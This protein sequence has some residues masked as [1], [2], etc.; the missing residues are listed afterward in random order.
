[1][2]QAVIETAGWLLFSAVVLALIAG[3]TAWLPGYLVGIPIWLA[4][5]LLIPLVRRSQLRQ[6]G[7]L[8]GIGL[9][10]LLFGIL[11]GADLRYLLQALGA[12]HSVVGMLIGVSFLRIVALAG[13][14]SDEALPHGR[15]ALWHTLFGT[16]LFGSV[17][18]V[19]AVLIVGDRLT[20]QRS[21]Q[22]LQGLTLLRSF[23]ICAFWSPFFASMGLTLV[24]APGAQL[25]TLILFGLPL[26]LVA[27]LFS[28]WEIGRHPQA[29]QAQGYPMHLRAL[30]M[31]LLLALLVI[32]AHQLWPT[33]SVLTLVTSV[34]LLFTLIWLPIR[35]GPAGL[36]EAVRHVRVGLPTLRGEI[37]LFAAAAMLAA[38]V[39]ATLSSL[40]LNLAPAHFGPLAACVTV[41]VLVLLAMSGMHPVTSVVLAGSVLAAADGDPNLLGL[42]LL[43][44][45]SLGIGLSPFSG[46]QLSLQSRYGMKAL[47]LLKLNRWYAGVM[48]CC[49]FAVLWLYD[50]LM[51]AAH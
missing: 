8:F 15:K 28:A 18:N 27:L 40:D 48:L 5:L 39:A 34:A 36:G 35:R 49:C 11:N 7:I 2:K 25:G 22:P 47:E 26:A 10:G 1:M 16:H 42:T 43:M 38:G 17:I 23:C 46:V 33:I 29:A 21:M 44:G 31:P 37:L 32:I 50:G 45:W 41:V 3:L 6:I 24:S 9:T 19:S 13:I 12:N 51:G 4:A 30:W 20:A 14:R